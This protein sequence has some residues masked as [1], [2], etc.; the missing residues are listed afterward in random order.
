MIAETIVEKIDN[1]RISPSVNL[2]I[3]RHM[4]ETNADNTRPV[5]DYN[6]Q[7]Y[8]IASDPTKV[9][10]SNFQGKVVDTFPLDKG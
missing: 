8:A 3:L 9:Q 5:I 10:F 2:D 6:A 4:Q 1:S 7:S